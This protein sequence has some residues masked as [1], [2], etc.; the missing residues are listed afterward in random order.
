M[1]YKIR[2]NFYIY[3]LRPDPYKPGDIVEL[4]PAQAKAHGHK[5]E[6]VQPTPKVRSG[7]R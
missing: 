4:T 6:A 7:D 2:D 1:Q 3:G 5:I